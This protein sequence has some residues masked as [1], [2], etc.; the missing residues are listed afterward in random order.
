ME[1]ESPEESVRIPEL[2]SSL[3]QPKQVPEKG[4]YFWLAFAV[5]STP[6]YCRV[7]RTFG[8]QEAL[9]VR[10]QRKEV[11]LAQEAR[12]NEHYRGRN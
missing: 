5:S 7:K 3:D 4:T 1:K 10:R 9:L 2:P 8:A 11:A 12:D 6:S